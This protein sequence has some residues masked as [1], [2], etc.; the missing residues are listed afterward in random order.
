MIQIDL[1]IFG[2]DSLHSIYSD[3]KYL[4]LEDKIYTIHNTELY[5]NS[6]KQKE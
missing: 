3:K 1:G 4:K 5:R 6:Q 2:S